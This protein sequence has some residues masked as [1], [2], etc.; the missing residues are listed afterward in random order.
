MPKISASIQTHWVNSILELMVNFN[1]GIIIFLEF[2]LMS[3][4]LIMSINRIYHLSFPLLKISN[5]SICWNWWSIPISEFMELEL[6]EWYCVE[7]DSTKRN[8]PDICIYRHAGA[9]GCLQLS[10]FHN[11]FCNVA[12]MLIDL[13]LYSNLLFNME[14]NIWKWSR[15][16]ICQ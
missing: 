5:N 16:Q 6:I 10:V 1:S 3:L 4:E 2:E 15:S 8:W 13:Q 7:L 12:F 14:W 11:E 9:G